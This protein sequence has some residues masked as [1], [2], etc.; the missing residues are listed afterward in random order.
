L[1]IQLIYGI[2]YLGSIRYGKDGYLFVFDSQQVVLAIGNASVKALVGQNVGARTDPAGKPYYLELAKAAAAGG[3]YVD[4]FGV[5]PVTGARVPKISYAGTYQPWGWNDGSGV[6]LAD[7]EA[8]Y[9][10]YLLEYAAI[11]V[12]IGAIVSIAMFLIIRNIKRSLG[13][14]PDYAAGI[15]EQIAAGDLSVQMT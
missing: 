11:L 12:C 10:R 13:G 5:A 14:E 8:A 9:E 3:G 1:N 7:I 6:F 4:Y 15:V 2:L